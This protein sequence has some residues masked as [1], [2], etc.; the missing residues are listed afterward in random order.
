M[1]SKTTITRKV[2]ILSQEDTLKFPLTPPD[3]AVV[4]TE[5]AVME[6]GMNMK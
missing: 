4:P 3:M 2:D 1:P 5:G 6:M